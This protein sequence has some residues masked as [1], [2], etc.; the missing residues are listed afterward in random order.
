MGSPGVSIVIASYNYGRFLPAA[1][2]S[3]LAQTNDVEL[4]VVD[5]GST[6]D[7]ADVAARLGVRCVRQRNQG[8]GV[9]RNRGLDESSGDFV[10]FLDA[11]DQ[12][13]G[14]AVETSLARLL[15]QPECACV[16]GHQ[17]LVAADGSPLADR[18]GRAARALECV[19]EDP[20]LHMLRRNSPLRATGAFLYRREVFGR[21]GRYRRG[22]AEDLDLNLRIA[23]T[24]RICCNDRV[25]LL[26][27]AHG[28]NATKN[29]ATMMRGAV[30]AQRR[31]R[32]Y[33]RGSAERRRAYREGLEL[34]HSYWGGHLGR[35]I[36]CE[37]REGQLR[38]AARDLATL[39]RYHPR[40]AAALAGAAA[41][42]IL[43]MPAR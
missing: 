43:A 16:Y 11:D 7:T 31:Q 36:A 5:D 40:G 32:R 8:P 33:T 28:D 12:L 10:L 14:D 39:L 29:W 4:L 25:V 13:V 23:R 26:A 37:A 3:A 18:P 35:Q 24:N 27:R 15:E 9:A 21:V 34:A 38:A 1:I 2:E 6:D 19:D 30:G 17:R 22:L 41:R 42:R 20:Y